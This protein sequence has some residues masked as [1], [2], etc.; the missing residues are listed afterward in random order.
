[1]PHANLT[2]LTSCGF[3]RSAGWRLNETDVAVC[4][5]HLPI[6]P[7]IYAFVVGRE[8]RYIGSALSGIRSRIIGYERKQRRL[9]AS[10]P[11]HVMLSKALKLDEQIE[12][13]TLVPDLSEKLEWRGLPIHLLLGLEAG[14]IQEFAPAWNRR[15][16]ALAAG[17]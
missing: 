5:G 4:E 8:V 12:V 1:V 16:R 9:S 11:V 13:Y 7:G 6:E 14:L 15:G 17:R 2:R 3:E 10:R